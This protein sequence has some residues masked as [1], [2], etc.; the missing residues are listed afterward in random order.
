VAHLGTGRTSWTE[1]AREEPMGNLT[2]VSRAL[3]AFPSSA[4][5][6]ASSQGAPANLGGTSWQLVQF[7]GGDDRTLIP[8]DQVHSHLHADGRVTV[9][10][11]QTV[12]GDIEVFGDLAPGDQVVKIASDSTQEIR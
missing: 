4:R 1:A 2:I 11:G 3:L 8:Q 7:K 6:Q 9:Q 5:S 10:T 12:N